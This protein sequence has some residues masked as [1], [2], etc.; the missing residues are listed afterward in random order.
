M[1]AEPA[2]LERSFGPIALFLSDLPAGGVEVVMSKLAAGFAERDISVDLVVGDPSG[3]GRS[4][5]AGVEIVELGR[6]RTATALPALARY[7]RDRRPRALVSAKDHANVVAIAAASRS[8]V[9]VVATV[10]APQSQA[11]RDSTRWTGH[12]VPW[13]TRPAY[14]RAGAVVAVSDGIAIDLRRD[15][16]AAVASKVVTIRNPVLDDQFLVHA[17]APVDHPWIVEHDV[18]LLVFAGRL[19]PQKDVATLLEAVALVVRHRRVRLLVVGDGRLRGELEAHARRLGIAD[20]IGFVGAQPSAA[21]YLAAA[22]VV[23]LTSRFEG[24]PTVLVE[25][26]ALG[27][28]VVSTD[29]PTGPAELLERGRYGRLVPVGEPDAFAV[30]VEAALDDRSAAPVPSSVLQPYTRE[31]ATTR[32]LDL[33]ERVS[34]RP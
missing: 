9:P 3:P 32:Y 13:L 15:L 26:L 8:H 4:L 30:A 31:F 11:S 33:I 22:D 29:C 12:I 14:R 1:A 18:P 21:P 27:R 25:A 20:A 7:I 17:A 19:E 16:P 6:S 24:L 23:V 34:A 28:A 5:F 10:H 2:R